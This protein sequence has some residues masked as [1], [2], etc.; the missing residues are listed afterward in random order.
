MDEEVH[1]SNYQWSMTT[2]LPKGTSERE[3]T[4]GKRDFSVK[5]PR[6]CWCTDDPRAISLNEFR[7]LFPGH[8][9]PKTLTSIEVEV[10]VPVNTIWR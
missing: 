4:E 10:Q 5:E 7:S 9:D 3:R 2:N 1:A 8:K 6:V